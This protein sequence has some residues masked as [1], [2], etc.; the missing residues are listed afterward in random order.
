MFS[1]ENQS[2]TAK[3]ITVSHEALKRRFLLFLIFFIREC[4]GRQIGILEIFT[5]VQGPM[6]ACLSE[7]IIRIMGRKVNSM[8]DKRKYGGAIV[9]ASIELMP[10]CHATI[11]AQN[12]LLLRSIWGKK[13]CLNSRE[14]FC[15]LK[16]AFNPMINVGKKKEKWR[17]I[18]AIPVTQAVKF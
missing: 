9:Y 16:G 6:I 5:F 7:K 11:I 3:F 10:R 15:R 1:I 4:L 18:L 2:N 8:P 17:P 12:Q 13:L 14:S